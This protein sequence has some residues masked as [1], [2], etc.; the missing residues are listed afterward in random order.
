MFKL[1]EFM[2][3]TQRVMM[4]PMIFQTREDLEDLR[5]TLFKICIMVSRL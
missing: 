4:E 1:E 3:N 2:E 5:L